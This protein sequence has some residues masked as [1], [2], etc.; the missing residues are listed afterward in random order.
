MLTTERDSDEWSVGDVAV[1]VTNRK[2][3]NNTPVYLTVDDTYRVRGVKYDH[4]NKVLKLK[5]I[6]NREKAIWFVAWR[7]EPTIMYRNKKVMKLIRKR[8]NR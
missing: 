6:D 1:C 3:K 8:S 2:I 4:I 7:F 5:I